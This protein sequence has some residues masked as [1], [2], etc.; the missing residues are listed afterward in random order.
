MESE[1]NMF[2]RC[3]EAN[4]ILVHIRPTEPILHI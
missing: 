3:Q 4:L 2:T 1:Q